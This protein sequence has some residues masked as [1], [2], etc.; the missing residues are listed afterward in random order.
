[1]YLPPLPG[2]VCAIF[3]GSF[4]Q[5]G[6]NYYDPIIKNV[7]PDDWLPVEL[8]GGERVS[9]PLLDGMYHIFPASLDSALTFHCF[10]RCFTLAFHEHFVLTLT[11]PS[12][13][14]PMQSRYVWFSVSTEVTPEDLPINPELGAGADPGTEEKKYSEFGV[15][16]QR[17]TED[18]LEE[19]GYSA[20]PR[21]L[22]SRIKGMFFKQKEHFR[23]ESSGELFRSLVGVRVWDTGVISSRGFSAILAAD[24]KKRTMWQAWLPCSAD[25]EGKLREKYFPKTAVAPH[26]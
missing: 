12:S 10:C 20:Y 26:G 2:D 21:G 5:V 6:P 17:V 22:W 11:S 13:R 25:V 15:G 16:R 14:A 4:P 18:L 8:P 3:G 9:S 19:F 24:L 7:D 23:K 1:M